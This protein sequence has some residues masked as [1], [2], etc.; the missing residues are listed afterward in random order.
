MTLEGSFHSRTMTK[1]AG[2]LVGYIT[3]AT[4][5][6]PCTGGT[7]WAHN[8]ETNE[9]LGGTVSNTLPWHVRYNSFT[10]T[11]PNI[12]AI[13]YELI[14][15]G[16]VVREGAFGVLCEYISNGEAAGRLS[17]T[18]TEILFGLI[19]RYRYSVTG[20]RSATGGC[21]NANIRGDGTPTV[22]GSAA[23]ISVTLI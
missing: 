12:T 15:V 8:G 23:G 19:R 5:K 14:N 10:G 20:K 11:L 7:V 22:L 13:A 2:A 16:Y 18:W 9:V 1:T 21:P 3:R 4:I 17:L 6:R